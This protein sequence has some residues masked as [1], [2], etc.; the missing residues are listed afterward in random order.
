MKNIAKVTSKINHKLLVTAVC[1]STLGAQFAQ[2][3]N[4]KADTS[5]D[6]APQEQ[7]SN[8]NTEVET[9]TPKT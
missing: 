5:I 8:E 9:E 1:V 6:P 3:T 7:S 2:I 4:V